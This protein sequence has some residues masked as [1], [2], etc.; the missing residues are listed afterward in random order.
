M[1]KN[2][3]N[4][5]EAIYPLTPLQEGMFYHKLLNDVGSEYIEQATWRMEQP[6]LIPVFEDSL[7]LLIK[8]HNVLRTRIVTP[9]SSDVPWQVVVKEQ[10]AECIIKDYSNVSQ[11]EIEQISEREAKRDLERGFDFAKDNLFRVTILKFGDHHTKVIWTFHHILMDGW[12][13]SIM[14]NDF[15]TY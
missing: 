1:S 7:A 3:T 6:L 10:K 5:V 15:A 12:C 13:M 2:K 4:N 8:K 9:K 14:I 11:D